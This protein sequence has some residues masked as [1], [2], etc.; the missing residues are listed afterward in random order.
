M[1]RTWKEEIQRQKEIITDMDIKIQETI[2][3]EDD[4][5]AEISTSS[6]LNMEINK[7]LA[8]INAKL[9]LSK[10]LAKPNIKTV[11]LPNISLIK[12]TG[13]PLQWSNFW[14]LFKTSIHERTDI[15]APAKF[16]Y[17]TSQLS[18]AAANLLAGFDNTEA[19]YHEAVSLLESTYGKKRILIQARL[20]AILDLPSPTPT[21]ADISEF[22]SQYEGHLRSLKSLGCNI[23][24][25]GYVFAE[26]LMRKLPRETRDHLNRAHK[27]STTWE[28]E[29]LRA[30]ITTEL[31]HLTAYEGQQ[32]QQKR[33]IRDSAP[34]NYPH[35]DN[36]TNSFAFNIAHP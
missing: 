24:E 28:L 11:K 12:F 15:A 27:S 29:D 23:V 35:Q 22:R 16:H 34:P 9:T 19:S 3:E 7:A 30:A 8:C 6:E 33:P 17:L 20:D 1:C 36:L 21:V 14:D 26:I 32:Q 25:A 5:N 31:E 2:S 4:L 10:E 13:D 18:G